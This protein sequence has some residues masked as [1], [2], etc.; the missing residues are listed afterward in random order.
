MELH[1]ILRGETRGMTAEDINDKAEDNYFDNVLLEKFE[2]LG[3]IKSGL[4][5]FT[6][7]F[8]TEVKKLSDDERYFFL[9]EDF[10]DI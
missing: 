10:G 7:N 2:N 4:V 8:Q 3:L 5:T 6:I 9:A 1:D